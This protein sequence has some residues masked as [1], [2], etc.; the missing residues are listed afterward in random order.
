MPSYSHGAFMRLYATQGVRGKVIDLD[1]GREVRKVIWLDLDCGEL[2]AYQ[3]DILGDE[4]KDVWGRKLTYRA[5]GRFSFIPWQ[6]ELFSRNV[7]TSPITPTAQGAPY[8]SMCGSPLTLPGDDLCISCR[9]KQ[10][11]QRWRPKVERLTTPLLDKKCCNCSRLA[12]W[13]VADEVEAS[14]QKL[15]KRLFERGA[16][17]G[18]RFYCSFCYKPPRLLDTKGEEIRELDTMGVRPS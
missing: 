11:V 18:Q 17:V 8:C 3:T 4:I 7:G 6:G 12:V 13:S 2:E 15:G 16:T 10:R 5:K 1:T 14:P 9:T